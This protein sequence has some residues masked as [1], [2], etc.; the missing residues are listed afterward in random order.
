MRPSFIIT[1]TNHE[2]YDHE[3]HHEHKHYH[4][5]EHAADKL[6]SD[7]GFEEYIEKHGYHF[8]DALAEHVSKMME[9]ANGQ[10]HTW[11]TTQV[12]KA[13]ENLGLNIPSNITPGDVTYLAN[14][15]YSDFYPDPLKD[16]VACLKAAHK[17]ANDNDGYDGM[18]FCRW[19]S[20][21]I[22]KSVHIDWD[23]FI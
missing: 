8:T 23:K 14:M 9:N 20:D 16:E 11:T 12:K 6:M 15:Y 10:Q 1:R 5:Y 19:M 18:V 4:E 21:A 13:M 2:E 22:G 3:H 17:I 7:K